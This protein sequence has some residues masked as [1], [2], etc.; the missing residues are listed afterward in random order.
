MKKIIWLFFLGVFCLVGCESYNNT[1]ITT[2]V[3]N[4]ENVDITTLQDGLVL[5]IERGSQS[6]VGITQTSGSL[7]SSE[8][9]IGSGVIIA[10]GKNSNDYLVLTNR[11]VISNSNETKISQKIYVVLPNQDE[12]QAEVITYSA[13]VDLALLR[14][15]YPGTL[16]PTQF[17]NAQ[18]LK[19]GHIVVAIGNPGS[20]DLYRT[21]TMG[22]ISWVER[23]SEDKIFNS[24]DNINNLYIQHDAAISPGNSGGGLFN[25]NGELIGINTA[26]LWDA[27]VGFENIGFSIPLS[28]INSFISPYM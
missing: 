8:S 9:F 5:A 4:Y 15:N 16:V 25:L 19:P 3:V 21:A 27:E 2:K 1:S 6:V 12:I 10:R 22:I 7:L 26:K 17:G 14:I 18:N 24:S 28:V 23:L 20:L 13:K 11:H